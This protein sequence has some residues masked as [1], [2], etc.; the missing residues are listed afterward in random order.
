MIELQTLIDQLP[1]EKID[2]A[3]YDLHF[4]WSDVSVLKEGQLNVLIKRLRQASRK[5]PADFKRE[6]YNSPLIRSMHKALKRFQRG[7][8]DGRTNT[9]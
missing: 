3:T 6:A 5:T 1:Q 2:Q 9:T 7:M 8:R 4:D